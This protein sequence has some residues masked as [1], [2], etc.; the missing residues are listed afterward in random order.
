MVLYK[1][2]L[3]PT[4]LTINLKNEDGG[5]ATADYTLIGFVR[6]D[7][8]YSEVFLKH[9][10]FVYAYSKAK[11]GSFNHPMQFHLKWFDNDSTIFQ[12]GVILQNT[13]SHVGP[14]QLLQYSGTKSSDSP[15]YSTFAHADMYIETKEPEQGASNY[16]W[17]YYEMNR[18]ALIKQGSVSKLEFEVFFT[19]IDGERMYRYLPNVEIEFEL[20]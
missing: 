20:F 13:L 8:A 9:V 15:S 5:N 4:L 12:P 3:Q 2:F 19:N 6:L 16:R 18:D 10:R 7:T 17:T 14:D 11:E 1:T